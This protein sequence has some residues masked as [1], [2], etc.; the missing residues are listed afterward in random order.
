MT[1]NGVKT[2]SQYPGRIAASGAVHRHINNGLMGIG[3]SP[4]VAIVELKG[5]QTLLTAIE[6]SP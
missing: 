4:V 2:Y 3:F 1:E 5:L 6:L